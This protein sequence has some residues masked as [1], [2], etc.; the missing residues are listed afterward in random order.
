MYVD[1]LYIPCLENIEDIFYTI[2]LE[3]ANTMKAC[4]HIWIQKYMLFLFDNL[5]VQYD[6]NIKKITMAKPL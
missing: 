4:I 2:Y 5:D 3:Y 6:P 1:K